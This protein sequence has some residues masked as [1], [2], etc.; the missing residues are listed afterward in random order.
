MTVFHRL[1]IADITRE[2]PDAVAITLQ[3]PKELRD[4]YYYT[5][6][7][8][9]TLK[10]RIGG[11]ELRRCYSICSSPLEMRLQIG[12]KAIPEGRFSG[13]VNTQ[14]KAGDSI[15]V[16]VPQ[17]QFGYQPHP[18]TSGN[19]LAIAA[20]SGITP[21]LSIIATTL[22]Q[23]TDSQFTLIYGNRTSRGVMFREALTD[24]KNRYPQRFQVLYLFSQENSDIPLLKGRI[25]GER[26]KDIG[27]ILL[28]YSAFDRAFICGPESL[29]DDAHIA[30][31]QAGIPAGRISSERFNTT[32]SNNDKAVDSAERIATRLTIVQDGLEQEIEMST[33]DNSILDAAMR[34]GAD[35]PYA[36][37]GG[38]CATCKCKVLAGEVEMG[39][40]Y[41]LEPDQIEAGFVLSCQSRPKGDGVV[42][43][44]DV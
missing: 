39:I 9:L 24:L 36:C 18:D 3:V 28:D 17:G 10:A 5:P 41:S 27:R 12:V 25:D 19:Y 11:E 40:N 42:L 15:E 20:G 30:L 23:E 22:Q 21:L 14:L 33:E 26:L 29:M 43:D 44:F 7:Q 34:Q 6:G 16:M 37:K 8:H 2:T 31:E 35:L 1:N 13:F 38:V 32:L 4:Y